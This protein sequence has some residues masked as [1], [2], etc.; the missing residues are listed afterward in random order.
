M[1]PRTIF[2]EEHE[3]FR[4]SVRRFIEAE[5][6]PHHSRWEKEGVVSREAWRKA[7]A[8]GILCCAIPEEYG[9]MGGDFLHSA[10][11]IEEMARAGASGPA[12]SLHSDIVAPYI[13]K[14]ANE[15]LRCR[16]LPPMATGEALACIA[17]TEPSGGSDLQSIRTTARREGDEFVINGQKVFITNAQGAD[18]MI[19][20]CK[21]DPAAGGK[22]ISLIMIEKT[23]AGLSLGRLLEKIGSKAMDT[24]EVFFDNVRVP[25]TNLIGV[26]NKGF[27]HLMTELAQERLIQCVRAVAV[28][29]TALQWTIDYVRERNAFGKTIGDFQATQFTLAELHAEVMVNR[30]FIDRCIELHLKGEFDAMDAAVAKLSSVE[31]QGRV[32]DR[33]LQLFGGWGYMLEM[34]IARAFADARQTRLAGGAIE[35]MKHII[36]RNVIK[37]S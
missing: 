7:G 12:F 30:V 25:I 2:S 27:V 4:N 28:A 29:E 9:G 10:V 22:G 21:T 23:R 3:L 11:V 8:A 37:Q 13:L 20:A 16:W 36:G 31:M 35:V 26:E 17:M 5:I 33:C 1:I 18:V 19:V 6:A 15:E 14:Y 24:S 34:P 32:L